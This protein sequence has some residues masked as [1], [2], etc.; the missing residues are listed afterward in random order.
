MKTI[1]GS[2]KS[3]NQYLLF[4]FILSY[5]L[6]ILSHKFTIDLQPLL[7]FSF[8][9]KP[10][11]IFAIILTPIVINKIKFFKLENYEMLM[12]VFFL[13]F[14]CTIFVAEYRGISLKL[15][16]GIL[17]MMYI[18]FVTRD[19]LY[20]IDLSALEK[21]LFSAGLVFNMISLF[22]YILGLIGWKSG[23]LESQKVFNYGL[24]LS[25]EGVPRLNGLI[26][27]PNYFVLFNSLFFFYYLTRIKIKKNIFGLFLTTITI[28]LTLSIGGITAIFIAFL[29]N[30]FLEKDKEVLRRLLFSLSIVLVL[31]V[32]IYFLLFKNTELFSYRIKSIKT[33]SYRYELWGFSLSLFKKNPVFGIG[34]YNLRHY[35]STM[36]KIS[37]TH[38]ISNIHNTFLKVLV[39]G[40]VFGFI[41]FGAFTVTLFK[42]LY[43]LAK[44]DHSTRYLFLTFIATYVVFASLSALIHEIYFLTLAIY[45]RY[46]SEYDIY[47]SEMRPI[48]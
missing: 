5:F 11:M 2:G 10:F 45:N 47:L 28:I 12:V 39:E 27:G 42:K 41:F 35:S 38:Y 37:D 36:F 40:G 13:Y 21:L 25:E 24:S 31:F 18:Y 32:L 46:I 7:S 48:A 4:F 1:N 6:Q 29:I 15:T 26:Y 44:C 20:K 16:I 8:H 23:I 43:K 30:L 34:L 3:F 17:I 9:L 14:I 33:G 19:L 22:L